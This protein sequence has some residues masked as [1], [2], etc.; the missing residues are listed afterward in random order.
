M[1]SNADGRERRYFPRISYR[2]D[3]TLTTTHK[4][5]P[6]HIM[7]LSFNG[8]LAAIV[9]KHDIMDGE[10]IILNIELDDGELFKMQG[11]ISHQYKHLLGIECRANGIDSQARLRDI[12]KKH[13]EEGNQHR[14]IKTM[15]NLQK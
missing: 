2:A 3:A 8:A 11:S 13:L 14:S 4:K 15:I 10:E 12:L 1:T 7:D 6:V 5:W 9:T